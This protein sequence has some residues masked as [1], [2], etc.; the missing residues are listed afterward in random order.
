VGGSSFGF[1]QAAGTTTVDGTLTS[2]TTGTLDITGGDVVGKGTLG[3]NVV[4]AGTLSP[5]DS[6]AKTGKLTVADTYTQESNGTLDIQIDGSTAAKY[7]QL[8][9]TGG[10]TL[11]TGST[12]DINLKAGVAAT[13]HSGQKFTILT[14]SA[15]TGTFT[16]VNGQVISTNPPLY[17]AV[18]YPPGTG[19]VVLTVTSGTPPTSPASSSLVSAQLIHAP[20]TH[21]SIGRSQ[22]GLDVYKPGMLRLPAVL[23]ALSMART[24]VSQPASLG[25]LGTSMRA[26]H[27]RDDFGS[28]VTAPAPVDAAAAGSLGM[29]PVSAAAYNSMGAMNHMR[30]EAGV[31]LKALLKTSRKQLLKGLWAAPDSPD[32]LS[33]GYMTFNGAH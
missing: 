2:T 9:V 32:A 16:A 18:S 10:A 30:F 31:D 4:D 29:S 28:P 11:D 19:T 21:G 25:S 17:F 27:P 3:Y 22:Y 5:G 20:L 6:A 23:P 13:L 12:L 8:K 14:S 1:T 26:F 24:P 7:D 15:L 33:I